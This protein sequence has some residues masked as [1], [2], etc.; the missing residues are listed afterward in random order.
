MGKALKIN[1]LK[2]SVD[3]IY[4]ESEVFSL[5]IFEFD[6]PTNIVNPFRQKE[7]DFD[8]LLNTCAKFVDSIQN[9]LKDIFCKPSEIIVKI[10]V[11]IIVRIV[12]SSF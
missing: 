5:Y 4:I 9:N 6:L 2:K 7:I 12:S 1:N 11:L 10:M 3:N 8:P